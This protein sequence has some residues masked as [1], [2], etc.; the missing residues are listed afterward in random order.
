MAPRRILLPRTRPNETIAIIYGLRHQDRPAEA[1]FYFQDEH[2]VWARA[3][4][5]KRSWPY[6]VLSRQGL[7]HPHA[8]ISRPP[9]RLPIAGPFRERWLRRLCSSAAES[10]LAAQG[11][12]DFVLFG[13]PMISAGLER[14]FAESQEREPSAARFFDHFS[15]SDSDD[16]IR[17]L[18]R[19]LQ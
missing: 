19:L 2:F 13:P 8:I 6:Y 1:R 4:A 7:S 9:P 15:C 5:L 17:A 14:A 3:F 11:E 18:K 10:L 16:R 12:C